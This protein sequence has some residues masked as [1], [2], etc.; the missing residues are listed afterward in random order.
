MYEYWY[1]YVK[2]NYRGKAKLCHTDTRNFIIHVKSENVYADIAG[3]VEKRI[4]SSNYK[5]DIPL[6]VGITRKK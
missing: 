5:V 2:L 1:D 3:D 6:V 4:D